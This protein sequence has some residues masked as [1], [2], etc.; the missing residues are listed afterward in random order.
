MKKFLII[1]SISLAI[2]IVLSPLRGYASFGI[3]GLVGFLFFFILTIFFEKKYREQKSPLFISGSVLLGMSLI[4]APIHIIQ[5]ELA[6]VSLP[7]Y[8]IHLSGVVFAYLFIII[9]KKIR[10]VIPTLGL[11]LTLYM[12]FWGY[13]YWVH[14][15]S[16]D[17]FTGNISF[18]QKPEIQG[19]DENGVV[20]TK[21]DFENKIVLFDFWHTACGE[22]F[23]EMPEVQKLY[24]KYKKNDNFK[25][26][27]C[28]IP[29]K[30]DT[31]GK[32]PAMIKKFGFSMP[33]LMLSLEESNRI[34]EKFKF[35]G[36]PTI[37]IIDKNQEVI[38]KGSAKNAENVLENL[39]K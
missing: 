10:F 32:A 2:Y 16:Y 36:V 6:L 25:L 22:C 5:W 30:T 37:L 14:Y 21:K 3:S 38:F 28:N 15:L 11:L 9:R 23:K 39:L 33:V 31:A 20:I 4:P 19:K 1:S 18:S 7:E 27:L 12:F 17:S 8:L 24:D 26:Y 29:I 34:L 35:N 13:D